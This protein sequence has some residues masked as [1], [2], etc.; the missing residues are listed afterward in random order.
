MHSPGASAV[1]GAGDRKLG[2]AD[3][4]V[5]SVPGLP[6]RVDQ[7]AYELSKRAYDAAGGSPSGRHGR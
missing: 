5:S 4:K 1:F 3:G 2:G 7:Q 6:V